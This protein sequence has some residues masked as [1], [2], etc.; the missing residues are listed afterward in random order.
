MF[1][2]ECKEETYICDIQENN[3]DKINYQGRVY[4]LCRDV[5]RSTITLYKLDKNI[6][7]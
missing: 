3:N 5:I 6:K 4:Y 1:K 2:F 7:S